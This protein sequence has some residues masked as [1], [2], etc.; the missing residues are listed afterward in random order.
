MKFTEHAVPQ[1][2]RGAEPMHELRISE[3][4]LLSLL[5]KLYT[6]GSVCSIEDPMRSI[7]VVAERDDEH[8]GARRPGIM[9]PAT[10]RFVVAIKEFL[11]TQ[12]ATVLD[13]LDIL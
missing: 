6:E 2:Y 11:A 5:S 13:P 1:V 3:R 12:D 8:Y 10:E 9:H 4:N 7:R